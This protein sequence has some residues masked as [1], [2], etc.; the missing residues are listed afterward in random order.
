MRNKTSVIGFY[1]YAHPKE[2]MDAIILDAYEKLKNNAPEDF[3]INFIGCVN[4]HDKDELLKIKEV[5]SATIKDSSS[6]LV[7]YAGWGESPKLLKVIEEFLYIPLI[8]W[9]L[10]GYYVEKGLIAPAAAAGVSLLKYSLDLM[11]IKNFIVFDNLDE[12]PAVEKVIKY[13]KIAASYRNIKNT[14]IVSIGYA[15]SNLF[16]FMYDGNII[17]KI[18]G[19]QVDN[20]ELLALKNIADSV[21]QDEIKHYE[22]D[23]RK[24][25]YKTDINNL[26]MELFARYSAAMESII[27]DG[28]YK[29]ITLK[30]G[31]DPGVLLGFTPCM[32]LSYISN[33]VDAI[34]ECDV[35]NLVLQVII[36]EITSQKSFFLEI[37]EFY[38]DGF[39]MASC[40]F[41]PFKACRGD[42][43]EIR[44][45]D[46]GGAKGI[47]NI[48][49]LKTGE[50]TLMNLS[51]RDGKLSLQLLKGNSETPEIFQEEGWKNSCGPMIPGL[52]I[53]TNYSIEKF[54][55]N[56][57][58]P[59]Y[60]VYYG[61]LQQE[62]T[63]YC[64][65]A[66]INLTILE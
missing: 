36:S 56:I 55:E 25:I 7:I 16:P 1:S 52:K 66:G 60:I 29:A 58:G 2:K 48:S 40:G 35:Y 44:E 14:S 30:C 57:A 62:M 50:I 46:W 39:L 18:T 6:L 10:S 5:V 21:S 3:E 42:C 63:A 65:L 59:H 4:D 15:C 49:K 13:I 12:E 47:M 38:S 61:D 41:A 64:R 37:F 11:N 23:L 9:S 45:H 33:K 17:K 27:K 22:N 34:C 20:I 43:I 32:V 53:K 19:I 8:V 24:Y 26:E 54:K 31:S 51:A 28:G